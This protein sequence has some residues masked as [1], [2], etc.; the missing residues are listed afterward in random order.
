MITKR[1]L[2]EFIYNNKE[3]IDKLTDKS[4][5][6]AARQD[7]ERKLSRRD[8]VEKELDNTSL[9]V[10]DLNNTYKSFELADNQVKEAF[11]QL[12]KTLGRDRDDIGKGDAV[13]KARSISRQ[14]VVNIKPKGGTYRQRITLP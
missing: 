14:G 10:E 9:K 2:D 3:F 6:E 1:D 11:I 5:F 8:M 4:A 7:V 13:I 12:K